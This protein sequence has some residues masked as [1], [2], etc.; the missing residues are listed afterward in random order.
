M[1][2]PLLL[3]S[4]IFKGIF[5]FFKRKTDLYH[6]MNTPVDKVGFREGEA[7]KLVLSS[8][9]RQHKLPSAPAIIQQGVA[10]SSSSSTRRT[11]ISTW[12]GGKT[13]RYLWSQSINDIT[14]ELP[15]AQGVL[16]SR[17]VDVNLSSSSIR[18]SVLGKVLIDGS[19]TNRI[20]PTES[21]WM[22]EDNASVI[23][24][25]E[26]AVATWWSSLL[27]GESEIDTSKIESTKRIDE[28]D[29]ETQA[30]IRKIMFDENQKRLGL[31][32]SDEHQIADKLKAAWDV[33]GSPFK[34][35]EFR[36]EIARGAQ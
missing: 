25:L 30:A 28:Y 12:N 27:A 9:R 32:T 11:G 34:G 19:F 5:A 1:Y 35:T 10:S 2:V 6:I 29:E 16:R 18:I 15:L 3:H 33:D 7:E 14:V 36:P 13:E 23:L 22:I 24:S 4:H 31:L 17:D 26:K 21:T 8:F 20:N